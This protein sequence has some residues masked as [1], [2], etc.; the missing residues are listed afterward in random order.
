[1]LRRGRT[2][3]D[4]VLTGS[5]RLP[6]RKLYRREKGDQGKV[7]STTLVTGESGMDQGGGRGGGRK[8]SDSA[9]TLNRQDLP[10]G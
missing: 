5:V 3:S 2:G 9:L 8:W 7:S 6:C 4:F 1:M 10:K